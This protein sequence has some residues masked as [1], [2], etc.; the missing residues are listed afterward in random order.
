M[1]NLIS[2]R[3]KYGCPR[4]L[5]LSM[6]N[7]AKFVIPVPPVAEQ[8]RIASKVEDLLTLCEQLKINLAEASTTKV[9]LA[10]AIVDNTLN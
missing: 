6:G 9:H 3:K 10:E 2:C 1:F 4:F 7:I 5:N 8:K